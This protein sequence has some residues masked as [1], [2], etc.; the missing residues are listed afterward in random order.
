MYWGIVNF[1]NLI[2][3]PLL[4]RSL[5]L[6]IGLWL[7]VSRLYAKTHL[8]GAGATFPY[9]VYSAWL[10]EFNKSH[11]DLEV[12]YQSLGSGAGVKQLLQ[13]T[14]DFGASDIPMTD[15]QMKKSVVPILH[16]PTV[17]GSISVLAN[18]P[19]QSAQVKD[20]KLS[21]SVLAEIFLGDIFYWDH[22]AIKQLNPSISLPHVPIYVVR[23]ADGSG[24]TALFSKLLSKRSAKWEE[25]VGSG[26]SLKWPVGVGARGNE[27]VM[28]SVIANTGAIGYVET[29]Y[30]EKAQM[31]S[32]LIDNLNGE[33]VKPETKSI[34]AALDLL[35]PIPKDLRFSLIDQRGPG[36]YPLSAA[37]FILIPQPS[38]QM[39]RISKKEN[40][41]HRAL[42]SLCDF[43]YNKESQELAHRLG[44][45]PLSSKMRAM[46][47]ELILKLKNSR[48]L[49]T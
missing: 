13:Q 7:G 2:K 4:I 33:Y 22:P 39:D 49:K 18:I 26:T 21:V 3:H 20:F 40:D 17:L 5:C 15:E 47:Y 10:S 45:V 23:R 35:N 11:P 12:S 24:T 9:P 34:Q 37:T 8:S 46:I 38:G 31:Y 1:R 16:F 48:D 27:G 44:F 32:V 30:A 41:K 42:I 6:V 19:G 28:A 29:L 25:K 43:I 14:I 36:V